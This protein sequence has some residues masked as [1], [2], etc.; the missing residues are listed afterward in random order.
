[1]WT[2][3]PVSTVCLKTLVWRSCVTVSELLLPDDVIIECSALKLETP[4]VHVK[5]INL[6]FTEKHLQSVAMETLMHQSDHIN[7]NL[8][9]C[10]SCCWRELI[11]INSFW[12][13]RATK[14][15]YFKTFLSDL[16]ELPAP[17]P[18]TMG[19]VPEKTE[20]TNTHT[21]RPSVSE[22]KWNIKPVVSFRLMKRKETGKGRWRNRPAT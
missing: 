17:G 7:I 6:S 5:Q 12:P 10:R 4:S 19:L 8:W 2:F 18:G 13:I 3:H 11:N 14:S 15:D 20:V 21:H 22:W 1:M 9:N 16:V